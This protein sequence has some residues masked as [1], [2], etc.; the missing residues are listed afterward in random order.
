[1]SKVAGGRRAGQLGDAMGRG[2]VRAHVVRVLRHAYVL[3]V[4]T[5]AANLVLVQK[6]VWKLWFLSAVLVC[7][8]G[9]SRLRSDALRCASSVFVDGTRDQRVCRC[10][11]VP[12]PA[13]AERVL[14][15]SSA[16]HFSG[17]FRWF[18]FLSIRDK[19]V[20]FGSK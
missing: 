5:L 13:G 15:R 12:A 17:P 6:D 2:L 8:A 16:A 10:A 14:R 9:L 19:K 11:H 4:R 18:F 20:R 7:S 1:M 3:Q